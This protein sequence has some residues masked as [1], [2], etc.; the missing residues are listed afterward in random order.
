[1][2]VAV[3]VENGGHGASVAAPM[4]RAIFDAY[5]L[6]KYPAPKAAAKAATAEDATAVGEEPVGD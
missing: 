6:G 4:A 2:A 5:L 3:L 1:L